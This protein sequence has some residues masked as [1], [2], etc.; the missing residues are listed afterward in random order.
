[1]NPVILEN[2]FY[3]QFASGTLLQRS[4]RIVC[5]GYPDEKLPG[6]VHP[7]G[8]L[9]GRLTQLRVLKNYNLG[10]NIQEKRF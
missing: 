9:M 5:P 1:M 10:H 8:F 6:Q 3:I 7:D 4:S 2:S